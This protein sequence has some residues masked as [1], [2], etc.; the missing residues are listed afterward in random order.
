MAGIQVRG[1]GKRYLLPNGGERQALYDIDLEIADGEF[2]SLL[3]PSGCGKTTLLNIMSGL[4]REYRGSVG[5]TRSNG[6]RAETNKPPTFSYMFQESRLLPWLT[7]RQNLRFVLDGGQR[8]RERDALIDEWLER[9]GLTG[10]ADLHPAQ[11][12][13]GMQQRV[14][15][16]RA[17]IIQ[18]EILFMDEPLSSLDELTA[19]RMR[20]ELLALWAEQRPTVVFVTHN[21]LEAVYLADRVL[22]MSPGPGS[23]IDELPLADE[24]PRPRNAEDT[25]L[26]ELSRRA[27]RILKGEER[28]RA[29]PANTY[30]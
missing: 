26:W 17:L 1:V 12:S 27:V 23:V 20:D 4:D 25:K 29:E 28:E 18:P 10:S 5:F 14:S 13:V 21:P 11:L 24:L 7:V 22:I 15:L 3:G 8:G 6:R 16:V 19:S 2:V 9:V 30:H